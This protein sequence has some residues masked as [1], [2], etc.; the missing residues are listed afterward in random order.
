MPILRSDEITQL[1]L[2]MLRFMFG[3]DGVELTDQWDSILAEVFGSRG[4]AEQTDAVRELIR[5][6][7][8]DS[9]R[10][11]W[12]SRSMSD[13]T[14]GMIATFA[15]NFL[16]VAII[17]SQDAGVRQVL[18]Y[19]Y[20]WQM[21]RPAREKWISPFIALGGERR[22]QVDLDQAAAARSYH[23]EFQVPGELECAGLIL[24]PSDTA[25]AVS[26]GELDESR[27]PVAH[28]HASYAAKPA[29]PASIFV[30]LPRQGLWLATTIAAI[31][32]TAVVAVILFPVQATAV[33]LG[34]PESAAALLIAAPAVFFGLLLT[35]GRENR[36]ATGPLGFLR[37]LLFTCTLSLFGMAIGIVAKISTD[38]FALLLWFIFVWNAAISAF[39]LLGR[40]AI[41]FVSKMFPRT[42][43]V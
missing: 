19:S 34:S 30:R 22:L 5:T 7:K 14:K 26:G 28:A 20:H 41:W 16:L 1:Q 39:L 18:K 4:A 43:K 3:V 10:V 40:L 12:P 35:G 21:H 11:W 25:P 9:E 6:G 37:V 2:S 29:D 38:W 31:F 13:A 17:D 36:L 32:T 8:W 33:W 23:L 15:T 42:R 27:A 24:P